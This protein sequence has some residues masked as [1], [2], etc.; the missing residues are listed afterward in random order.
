MDLGNTITF[1]GTK[2]TT[3]K[4]EKHIVALKKHHVVLLESYPHIR[5]GYGEWDFIISVHFATPAGKGTVSLVFATADD[6]Y[7]AE[8]FVREEI[9]EECNSV[10][11]NTFNLKLDFT[12]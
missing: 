2:R 5:Q 7:A 1:I 11:E 9:T 12:N 10:L 6:M 3:G 8:E 4:D